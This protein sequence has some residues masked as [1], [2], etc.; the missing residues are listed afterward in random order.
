MRILWM[1]NASWCASGYGQQTALFLPRLQH[2]GHEMGCFAY[3]GLQGGGLNLAGINYYPSFGHAYG[4]DVVTAHYQY[5]KADLMISLM[6]TWVMAPEQYPMGMFWVPW[7]PVD[8][9]PMPALVRQKIA[10]AFKRITYSKFGV[11]K[12]HEAGLDCYYIPHGVDTAIF[13]PGDKKEAREHLGWP[14]DKYIVTTVAM[15]KGNPSRK[16]FPEMAQAFAAFHKKHPDTAWFIQALRGDVANDMVNIPEM[17]T[18]M[19]LLEG[20]DWMMPN[21]YQTILGFPPGYIVELYRAS[22]VMLL[23]SAGEGFGLPILEAQACGCPVI[24]SGWTANKEL[25]LAG[26]LVDKADAYPF[27]T[28]LASYQF[29]P[30]WE[31]VAEQLE[32][33][34]ANPSDT[35][36]AVKTVRSEYD[37]DII[38]A[39]KWKPILMEIAQA[40]IDNFNA[41]NIPPRPEVK[42]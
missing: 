26:R 33:E 35:R 23:V 37:A 40:K 25:C 15:N 20:E 16:N 28:S 5:H 12:T 10:Q 42:G 9:D 39:T 32:A 17:L 6:D 36:E 7:Y 30:R 31:A 1:S 21:Q 19:G 8:H 34:Y 38:T 2:L 4:N 3:Y 24:T 29:K 11:E 27:Y 18:G 41:T 14:K 22:D 13:T